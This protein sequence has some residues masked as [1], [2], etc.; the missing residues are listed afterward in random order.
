MEKNRRILVIEDNPS[1]LYL[2][3]YLLSKH[4][5]ETIQAETGQLG[6]SLAADTKPLAIILDIQLPEM[7]GYQ[8]ARALRTNPILNS[9]PIIAVTSYAM[10]GDKETALAAGASAYIEKPINPDTFI[11]DIEAH[12]SSFRARSGK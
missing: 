11:T 5:Y 3:Q 6:I 1:N 12:I 7:D 8:V 4:D 9:T 10:V 2:I